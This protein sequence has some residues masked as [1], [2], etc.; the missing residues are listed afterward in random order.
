MHAFDLSVSISGRSRDMMFD[1]A[2]AAGAAGVSFAGFLLCGFFGVLVSATSTDEN[3]DVL[4][5]RREPKERM[6]PASGN[7]VVVVI[8]N[9]LRALALQQMN[10]PLSRTSRRA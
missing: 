2:G 3:D 10:S 1:F 7:L 9:R 6:I 8:P 4:A 5:L